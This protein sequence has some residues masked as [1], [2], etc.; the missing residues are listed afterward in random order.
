VTQVLGC[1]KGSLSIYISRCIFDG[2][3][4]DCGGSGKGLFLCWSA[5]SA[6]K[7][8]SDLVIPPEPPVAKSIS[9]QRRTV[10][11]GAPGF[12]AASRTL[13]REHRCGID[14]RLSTGGFGGSRGPRVSCW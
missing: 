4:G 6:D 13:A 7:N 8:A 1:C 5:A 9:P 2:A 10:G 11:K 14:Y 12:G 3:D